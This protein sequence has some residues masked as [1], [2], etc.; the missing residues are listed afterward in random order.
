MLRQTCKTRGLLSVGKSDV[1]KSRILKDSQIKAEILTDT[2]SEIQEGGSVYSGIDGNS[3][4]GQ[5]T[6]DDDLSTMSYK[7]LRQTCK[8]RG[9]LS[10]GKS[11]VLKSRI[12]KDSQIKAEI[13]IDTKS[14][15]QETLNSVNSRNESTGVVGNLLSPVGDLACKIM[16]FLSPKASEVDTIDICDS[17]EDDILS[18]NENATKLKPA[19]LKNKYEVTFDDGVNLCKDDGLN[20]EARL[21]VPAS[22]TQV[23]PSTVIASPS[24]M[25]AVSSVAFECDPTTYV[26][27]DSNSRNVPLK[28]LPSVRE[29]N[30]R[31]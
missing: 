27:G 14:E 24:A 3:K 13:L 25:S 30:A 21:S 18:C 11:D 16:N 6:F 20:E 19:G 26:P 31:N 10:V 17:E 22:D 12:L 2:K 8:T 1:L 4:E 29:N 5:D 15:I 23:V 7:M 9:L 28:T